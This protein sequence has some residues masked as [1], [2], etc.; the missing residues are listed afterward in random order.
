MNRADNRMQEFERRYKERIERQLANYKESEV[1]ARTSREYQDFKKD[2]LPE[3][4]SWYEKACNLA[5]KVFKVSADKKKTPAIQEAID[6][7]HLNCTPTGVTSLSFALPLVLFLTSLFIAFVLPL[8]LEG[9]PN[10]VLGIGGAIGSLVGILIL[11]KVPFL[12]ANNWRMKASNQMV[13]CVFYVVTYMRHTSN[14]ENAI[15]FAAEHLGPP[16]SIDMKKILW[17]LETE[18]YAT[19]KESLDHYLESWKKWNREFIEAMHLVESSLYENSEERR[20]NSLDKSLSIILEETYEKMLHY[21][22]NLKG[23]LTMLHMLGIVLPILGLVILPLA[24]SFVGWIRWY[25]LFALYNVFL[26]VGVYYLSKVILSTRPTGYGDTDISNNPEIKKYRNIRI[27]LGNYELRIP[28]LYLALLVFGVLFL[29]GLSPLI[30]DSLGNTQTSKFDIILGTEGVKT[31]RTFTDPTA[32]YYLL[33][34]IQ[35]EGGNVLGPYGLGASILSL[36]LTLA[37]GL[38]LGAYYRLRSQNIISIR[39]QT[40]KI[41]EE[42]AAALFQLGNRLG[43][44]LPVEIAFE[45]VAEVMQGTSSAKFFEQVTINMRKKGMRIEEAIFDK[46]QGAMIYYPSAI[47]ESAMKVLIESSK[48]GTKIAA[49]ALINVSQYIKEMHRVDERLKDLMADVISSMKS[50]IAFLTPAIAGIVIGITSMITTILGALGQQ[51]NALKDVQAAE[52]AGGFAG[53]FSKFLGYGIPTYYFQFIVGLY[54][55]QI[56]FILSILVNG[57]QNG[58]DKLSERNLLGKNLVASTLLYVF[59]A[60]G[61][62]IVFNLIAGEIIGSVNLSAMN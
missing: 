24:V 23:P 60:F 21:A 48:K 11:Q 30:M 42:F 10:V 36:F 9:E 1:S 6:I 27:P 45:K 38:G 50:Q 7:C 57:I 62:V 56:V 31:I 2:Y 35:D 20:I 3:H 44:E 12:M 14:L 16:L 51:L 15:N 59:L 26:P 53:L 55:V 58:S 5:E 47:I 17:D 29:I 22:H 46:N 25:H 37:A 8:L 54:V 4:L 61:V 40:K 39:K 33:G 41:E 49:H 13:L 52:T 43:D 32:Q 18:K 28:P 19:V 34:Y